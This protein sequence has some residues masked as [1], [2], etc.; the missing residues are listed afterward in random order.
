M[1]QEHFNLGGKTMW[2]GAALL[3]F[4][5]EEFM[6]D[7]EFQYHAWPIGYSDLAPYYEEA[8][9]LLDV[10]TFAVEPDLAGIV[11]QLRRHG[12][13][14]VPLNLGLAAEIVDHPD[15]A[16]RFDGFAL[17]SGRKADADARLIAKIRNAPNLL[18][19]TGQAVV[20]LI[21]E[22]ERR[23]RVAGVVCA[24]GS[25]HFGRNVILA[26]GALHS[27]RILFRYLRG[28]WP[29]HRV[30]GLTFLGRYYKRH[31][32]TAVVA[33]SRSITTDVVRKTVLLSHDRFPHS[34]A[35]PLFALDDG[36]MATQL[37]S[38][39]PASIAEALGRHAY[40]FFLQTEDGS[41]RRN[42][43]I[44][45]KDP[46]APTL[47]FDPARIKPS[48]AEHRRFVR[49]FCRS[50]LAAG[51]LPFAKPIPIDGTAHVCGTMIAGVDPET[52]VVG[53]DGRVH[54]FEN[55]YVCDGSVL[56]RSSRVNPALTIYAWSLRVAD[57]L[58]RRAAGVDA[59]AACASTAVS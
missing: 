55:L 13:R 43:I 24:D 27:P 14:D 36:M 7:S 53:I 44:T 37:P 22:G 39:I 48:A 40:G 17:P 45:A 18:I 33:F 3:R 21:S 9:R 32:L 11:V 35:Q 15:E 31:L 29:Q 50:L 8:E 20:E 28:T 56:P 1:P 58:A 46:A 30:G 6:A 19:R 26:A 47:D 25:R 51:R 57:G 59:S 38:V 16:K 49:A 34:S 42:R 10:R 52:S 41:H 5:P 23:D 12:W 4:A 2:Y 54:G